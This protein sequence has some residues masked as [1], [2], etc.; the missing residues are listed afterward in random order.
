M[1]PP[2][3]TNSCAIA[4]DRTP[5]LDLELPVP[6]RPLPENPPLTIE[7]WVELCELE[8]ALRRSVAL[9]KPESDSL[10]LRETPPVRH[11]PFEMKD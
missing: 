2:R 6:D 10:E 1:E 8:D 9:S 4:S 3:S 11:A 5:D 7:A